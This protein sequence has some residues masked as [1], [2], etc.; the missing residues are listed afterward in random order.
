MDVF[1]RVVAIFIEVLLMAAIIYTLV[2][3][4]R[5]IAFDLG[6]GAKYKKAVAMVVVLVVGI[7][8]VFFIAHLTSFYPTI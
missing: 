2:A 6:L 7:T 4:V 1:L 5:L 3:G 8:T